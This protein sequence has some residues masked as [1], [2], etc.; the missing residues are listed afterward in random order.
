MEE[1]QTAD[2]YQ[3]LLNAALDLGHLLLESAESHIR[4]AFPAETEKAGAEISMV[5]GTFYGLYMKW[6]RDGQPDNASA[7]ADRLFAFLSK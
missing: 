4:S 2:E 7:L 3:K 6:S 1:L 5:A